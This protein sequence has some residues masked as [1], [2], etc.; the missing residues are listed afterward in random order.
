MLNFLKDD[1]PAGMGEQIGLF[2][3]PFLCREAMAP[4]SI[5]GHKVPESVDSLM[6]FYHPSG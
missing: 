2:S 1:N 3:T 5:S 4:G 6:Q